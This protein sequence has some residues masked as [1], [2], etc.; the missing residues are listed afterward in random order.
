MRKKTV[1]C[2]EC[3]GEVGKLEVALNKKLISPQLKEFS[4]LECLSLSLGCEVEDLEI[5][6]EEYKEQGCTMF[7]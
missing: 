7:L 3:N 4:C 1:L 6:I 5:K 2:N